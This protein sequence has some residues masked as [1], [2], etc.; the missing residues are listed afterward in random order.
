MDVG[1]DNE[2]HRC[3]CHEDIQTKEQQLIE[4]GAGAGELEE[5]WEVTIEVIDHIGTT[6]VE[7]GYGYCVGQCIGEG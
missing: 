5:L 7:C 1:G 4:L 2:N 6:E 3:T